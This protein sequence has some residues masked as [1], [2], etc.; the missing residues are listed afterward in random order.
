MDLY[1]YDYEGSRYI[2][3]KLDA[4]NV[5]EIYRNVKINTIRILLNEGKVYLEDLVSE[6]KFYA[7][8]DRIDIPEDLIGSMWCIEDVNIDDI[9]SFRSY[10]VRN[11]AVIYIRNFSPHI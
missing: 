4:K 7:G 3:V 8:A 5:E 9:I 1:I 10:S 11:I 6:L 2:L